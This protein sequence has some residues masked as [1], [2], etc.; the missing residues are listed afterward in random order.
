MLVRLELAS[1]RSENGMHLRDML[2][3]GLIGATWTA[4]LPADLAAR[5][6]LLIDTPED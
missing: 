2:D 1:F 4:R 5:L 6:Q 3:V